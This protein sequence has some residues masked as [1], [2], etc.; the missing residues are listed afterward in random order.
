[1]KSTQGNKTEFPETAMTE[2]VTKRKGVFMNHLYLIIEIIVV[3]GLLLLAKKFFGV[4]GV[5]A[6]IAVGTIFANIFE[7]KNIMLFGLNVAAGHVMFG[8]VFLATDILS[9][10][11]GKET[12]KKGVW[13]GL[14]ADI[15]LIACSQICRFYVPSALDT[16]DPAVQRLFSMSLRITSASAVMFFISNWCDVLLFNKIKELTDG[17]YLWLRNNVATIVCNCLENFLFYILAFYPSFSMSQIMSMGL[18]T[19]LLEI[20]I[21]LCDTPFLYMA[22]HI[23]AKGETT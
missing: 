23:K 6:W 3:F 13:I 21:G 22:T 16:A 8:S 17:K 4:G 15:A 12:A 2:K 9:E 11:Y 20:V 1:M 10:C 7:A 19:C 5:M 18:A 14:A